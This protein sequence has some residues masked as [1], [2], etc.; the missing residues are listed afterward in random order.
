MFVAAITSFT[1]LLLYSLYCI[2]IF[3][4]IFQLAEYES[5]SF[6]SPGDQKFTQEKLQR[7]EQ[8][9]KVRFHPSK[10]I[11]RHISAGFSPFAIQSQS[12]NNFE[13]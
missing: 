9:N 8:V 10:F 4:P 3:S 11:T 5:Q 12:I 7:L 6:M 13:K 2:S 1:W